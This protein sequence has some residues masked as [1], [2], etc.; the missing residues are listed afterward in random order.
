MALGGAGDRGIAGQDRATA[1]GRRDPELLLKL[2][3]S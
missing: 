1:T 3:Q 2:K